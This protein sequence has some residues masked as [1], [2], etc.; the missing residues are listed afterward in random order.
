MK[1]I[2]SARIIGNEDRKRIFDAEQY[3]RPYTE[4]TI[5][6]DRK[7]GYFVSIGLLGEDGNP[8][9]G[10]NILVKQD[11]NYPWLTWW[12]MKL[13][14]RISEIYPCVLS[15]CWEVVNA[16]VRASEMPENLPL[17]APLSTRE[18]WY[19]A[20]EEVIAMIPTQEERRVIYTQFEY[21]KVV[22]NPMEKYIIMEGDI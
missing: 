21:E 11:I 12:T 14:E 13:L 1:I 9:E 18:D 5:Y 8:I 22:L 16:L 7:D 20:V 3:V 6:P 19:K 17:V 15:M 10:L 2:Q 4:M